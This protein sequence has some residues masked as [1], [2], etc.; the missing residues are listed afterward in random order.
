MG[1]YAGVGARIG[2]ARSHGRCASAARS[3]AA[4]RSRHQITGM[5]LA[6]R[7]VAYNICSKRLQWDSV[8]KGAAR[9][10]VRGD[11]EA[12]ATAPAPRHDAAPRCRPAMPPRPH[13]SCAQLLLSVRNPNRFAV[14]IDTV[15]ADIVY[16]GNKVGKWTRDQP[17][18]LQDGAITDVRAGLHCR[19]R[20]ACA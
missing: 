12:R 6:P 14:R 3:L 11:F 4:L 17:L 2:G 19:T 10:G 7:G 15:D 13:T 1:G 20:D 16:N 5:V 18:V 8:F 9:F